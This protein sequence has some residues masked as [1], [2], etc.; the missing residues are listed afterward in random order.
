[1]VPFNIV[2]ELYEY[3]CKH[4]MQQCT[5]DQAYFLSERHSLST[6]AYSLVPKSFIYHKI[7]K[8]MVAQTNSTDGYHGILKVRMDSEH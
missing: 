7:F 2:Q 6:K 3:R 8:S 5:E 1:M 4:K